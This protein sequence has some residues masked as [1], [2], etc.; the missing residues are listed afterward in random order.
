MHK[1]HHDRPNHQKRRM[2][3][4]RIPI[5]RA[6]ISQRTGRAENLYDRNHA[7]EHKD[8]PNFPVSLE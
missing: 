1:H 3:H 5:G 7:K 2:P 8:D 4:N 6:F